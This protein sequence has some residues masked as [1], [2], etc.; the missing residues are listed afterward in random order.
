MHCFTKLNANWRTQ[1]DLLPS[2]NILATH[3]G[4]RSDGFLY[5]G[6]LCESGSAI[7][8]EYRSNDYLNLVKLF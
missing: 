3:A 2:C 8:P 6:D 1:M 7:V 5:H 4:W